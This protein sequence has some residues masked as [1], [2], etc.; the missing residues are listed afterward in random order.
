MYK[1]RNIRAALDRV[2]PR[3]TLTMSGPAPP[4]IYK[5]SA[6]AWNGNSS[7]NRCWSR[8]DADHSSGTRN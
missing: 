7:W 1:V 8:G 3:V 5:E 6:P 2:T 4:L